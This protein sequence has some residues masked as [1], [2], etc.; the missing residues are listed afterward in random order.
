VLH[1]NGTRWSVLPGPEG[2]LLTAVTAVSATDAWV[3]GAAGSQSLVLHC[4]GTA[5]SS[6]ASPNPGGTTSASFNHL[7][8]VTALSPTD[9]WAVGA[10]GHFNGSTIGKTLVLH[11]DGTSWTQV[12][13]PTVAKSSALYSVTASS[14]SQAWAVGQWGTRTVP[15]GALILDWN[16]TSWRRT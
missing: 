16:G 3:V 11:W 2:G 8:S 14:A 7:D 13:S 9:A 1:W 12:A 15:G 6:V 4:T 10:Y 5:C